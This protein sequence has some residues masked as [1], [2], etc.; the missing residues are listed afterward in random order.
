MTKIDEQIQHPVKRLN[1]CGFFLLAAATASSRYVRP[2]WPH[3]NSEEVLQGNSS[4][5]RGCRPKEK[6]LTGSA[7]RILCLL[8][9]V[10]SSVKFVTQ[11]PVF[12]QGMNL[13]VKLVHMIQSV[14]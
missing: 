2:A 8:Q 3:C 11:T 12:M 14:I 13:N 9:S 4:H 5:R 1:H 10:S 7:L 6:E